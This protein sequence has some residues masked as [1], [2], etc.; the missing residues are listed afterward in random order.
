MA[1]TTIALGTNFT[2]TATFDA[3]GT[4]KITG[5]FNFKNVR[6]ERP[7]DGK[8]SFS[9]DFISDGTAGVVMNGFTAGTATDIAGWG[10]SATLPSGFSANLDSWSLTVNQETV[11]YSTFASRWKQSKTTVGNVT[12]SCAGVVQTDSPL[13]SA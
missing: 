1:T 6:M 5:T 10:G 12:G 8:M 9:A 11:E 13:P 4:N 3:D 2:G 7:H